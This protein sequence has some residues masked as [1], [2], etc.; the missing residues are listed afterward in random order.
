MLHTD[1]KLLLDYLDLV[2]GLDQSLPVLDLV[3]IDSCAY[4]TILAECRSAKDND[5][6][7]A[8][9]LGCGAMSDIKDNLQKD[10]QI[11]VI[12]GVTAAV[13]LAE[14]LV[15]LGLGTSKYGDFDYPEKKQFTG[16][17]SHL[18]R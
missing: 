6:I 12:D 18:S 16:N 17:F 5:K 3:N 2:T 13:K 1:Q 8:I 4:E 9:V 10:L 11:P 14:S 15:S 7:G